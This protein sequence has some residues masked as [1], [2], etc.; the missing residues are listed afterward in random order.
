MRLCAKFLCND[1]HNFEIKPLSCRTSMLSAD[2]NLSAKIFYIFLGSFPSLSFLLYLCNLLLKFSDKLHMHKKNIQP[3]GKHF[4]IVKNIC[5]QSI[6]H[7]KALHSRL[8][9]VYV[10]MTAAPSA[11]W[12]LL[13]RKY[14]SVAYNVV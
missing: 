12:H 10:R 9:F 6:S 8:N 4:V 14:I 3:K 7:G 13:N 11:R 5:R 2:K 1:I